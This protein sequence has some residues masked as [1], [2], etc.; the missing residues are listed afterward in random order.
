MSARLKTFRRRVGDYPRRTRNPRR[1]LNESVRAKQQ[2]RRFGHP[3]LAAIRCTRTGED[4]DA[5][6]HSKEKESLKLQFN[7]REKDRCEELQSV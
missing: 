6:K 3:A 1:I 5:L 7:F 4:M 2:N